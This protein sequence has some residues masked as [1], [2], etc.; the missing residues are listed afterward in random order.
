MLLICRQNTILKQRILDFN[1][2]VIQQC[3]HVQKKLNVMKH[4]RTVYGIVIA[5]EKN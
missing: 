2:D 1:N 4:S 5:E 3:V